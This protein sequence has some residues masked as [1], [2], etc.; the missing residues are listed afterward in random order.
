MTPSERRHFA[1]AF[2]GGQSGALV[3]IVL[4]TGF[5]APMFTAML[6]SAALPFL[7]ARRAAPAGP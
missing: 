1:A 3:G 4:F 5:V 2:I 7:L 6:G